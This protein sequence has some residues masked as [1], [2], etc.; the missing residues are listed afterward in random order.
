[1]HKRSSCFLKVHFVRRTRYQMIYVMIL[2]FGLSERI[3]LAFL[4]PRA[5]L[6]RPNLSIGFSVSPQ[7]PRGE[8]QKRK[9][10]RTAKDTSAR[11]K[12]RA[13]GRIHARAHIF[14]CC[15]RTGSF[16]IP[17]LEWPRGGSSVGLEAR[18]VLCH[19]VHGKGEFFCGVR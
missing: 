5:V 12:A 2:N 17:S 10:T 14:A 4:D 7:G 16:F 11:F 18:H 13:Q 1:M 3:F 6:C 19:G 15:S 9:K 8:M